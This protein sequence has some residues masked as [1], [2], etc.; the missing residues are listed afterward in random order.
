ML[1]K[2]AN[3]LMDDIML[4]KIANMS[5]EELSGFVSNIKAVKAR[6]TS[7]LTVQQ[8]PATT[9]VLQAARQG[10]ESQRK[11]YQKSNIRERLAKNG[12]DAKGMLIQLLGQG[13][14]PDNLTLAF[15]DGEE[16]TDHDAEKILEDLVNMGV[17]KLDDSKD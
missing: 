14:L 2:E 15:R 16:F 9:S 3:E 5:R 1:N 7:R 11:L 10:L 13:K 17:V 12:V 8:K 4:D 6:V